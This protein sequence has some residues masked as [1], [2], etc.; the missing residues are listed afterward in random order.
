VPGVEEMG[1]AEEM[2]LRLLLPV[3]VR[4]KGKG[5]HYSREAKA[6]LSSIFALP[7]WDRKCPPQHEH[8]HYVSS[9][10]IVKYVE[11]KIA[12]SINY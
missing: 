7:C 8:E 4:C 11:T 5:K 12:T 3:V 6:C 9:T 10:F 1:A 2:F